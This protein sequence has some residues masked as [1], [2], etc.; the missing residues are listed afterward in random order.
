MWSFSIIGLLVHQRAIGAG[1]RKSVEALVL[2]FNVHCLT[3]I[4]FYMR[5]KNNNGQ[6]PR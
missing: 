3:Y 1:E 2:T 4:G 5:K 6:V